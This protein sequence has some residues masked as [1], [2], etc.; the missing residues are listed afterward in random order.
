MNSAKNVSVILAAVDYSD[1]S[2]RALKK[3]FDY[4]RR[5]GSVLHVLHV[6]EPR[7]RVEGPHFSE[8]AAEMLENFIRVELK[9]ASATSDDKLPKVVSHLANGQ[10]A[11]EVVKLADE[12]N[13]TL[14]V[15]GG[16]RRHGVGTLFSSSVAEQIVRYSSAP[17]LVVPNVPAEIA[18]VPEIEPACPQCVAVRRATQGKELWCEQHNQHHERRHTFHYADRNGTGRTANSLLIPF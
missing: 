17:V 4:A 12:L 8:Q 13:P 18:A 1:V 9:T 10:P 15:V 6:I 2:R 5:Q 3:A 11:N 14:V 7:E 16:H